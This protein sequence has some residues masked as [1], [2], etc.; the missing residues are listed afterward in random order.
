MLSVP[1][2]E[3]AAFCAA[4]ALCEVRS[5]W[6]DSKSILWFWINL[7]KSYPNQGKSWDV[8]SYGSDSGIFLCFLLLIFLC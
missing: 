6:I 7:G 2:E 1:A 4:E 5:L 8:I 3:I